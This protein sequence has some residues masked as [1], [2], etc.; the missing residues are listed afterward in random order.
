MMLFLSNEPYLRTREEYERTMVPSNHR[1]GI[2][3]NVN[4]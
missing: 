4:Q 1:T 2:E 3:V